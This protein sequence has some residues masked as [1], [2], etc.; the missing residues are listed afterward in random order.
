MDARSVFLAISDGTVTRGCRGETLLSIS[1]IIPVSRYFGSPPLCESA[2]SALRV[3]IVRPV[4]DDAQH[5]QYEMARLEW[6]PLQTARAQEQQKIKGLVAIV[7]AKTGFPILPNAMVGPVSCCEG[8]H[9]NYYARA[10][11]ARR[12]RIVAKLPLD[13]LGKAVIGNRGRVPGW[14]RLCPGHP[15]R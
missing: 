2:P 1:F 5:L 15:F 11:E 6:R 13:F 12:G 7:E 14:G 4:T 8:R 10:H 9:R 3:W